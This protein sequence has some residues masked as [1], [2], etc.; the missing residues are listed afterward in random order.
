[1]NTFK[2]IAPIEPDEEFDPDAYEA[3][4]AAIEQM[5][6][7]TSNVELEE[8]FNP[9]QAR[10]PKGH[11]KAG[12]WRPKLVTG[13]GRVAP[14]HLERDMLNLMADI[15]VAQDAHGDH[16]PESQVR[17]IG[18]QVEKV[19]LR[20][21]AR[22]TYEKRLADIKAERKAIQDPMWD[23]WEKLSPTLTPEQWKEA[24]VR[25]LLTPAES[26]KLAD[27]ADE[28]I[29]TRRQRD[30][31]DRDA[32]LGVLQRIRPM[33]GRLKTGG[34]S[35]DDSGDNSIYVDY[36]T[37][38]Q[39]DSEVEDAINADLN[40]SLKQVL[41][42]IPKAWLDDTNSKGTVSWLF[43]MD[44][45]WASTTAD[46]AKRPDDSFRE[47]ENGVD[48]AL[49]G[50][51]LVGQVD[52][53]AHDVMEIEGDPY[54]HK[55]PKQETIDAWR[56]RR[57]ERLQTLA[58]QRYTWVGRVRT[59]NYPDKGLWA[60]VRGADDKRDYYVDWGGDLHLVS[61]P[62][63]QSGVQDVIPGRRDDRRVK[64]PIPITGQ[65]QQQIDL[66]ISRGGAYA[67]MYD[68]RYPVLRREGTVEGGIGPYAEIYDWVDD[69][70]V[71]KNLRDP[72]VGPKNFDPAKWDRSAP[73]PPVLAASQNTQIKIDPRE[74][75]ILLHELSHRMEIVYGSENQA[76]Y[77]PIPSATHAWRARRTRG[78]N[79]QKLDYLYPNS[80]YRGDEITYP[81]EF[82]DAYIGKLYPGQATEVLSMGMDMLWF[83]RYSERD[84]N[85]DPDMRQLILGLQATL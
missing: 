40:A 73:L 82:V 81:D 60:V 49:K 31:A 57:A 20:Y 26:K 11:P 8:A 13:A 71:M 76:G 10:F 69:N 80:D 44:R 5:T 2:P 78:E 34:F 6:G 27:L 83:P 17:A 25:D 53:A 63:K 4:I 79:T 21:S 56:E 32:M 35:V 45:A 33:G 47:M 23:K 85:Q 50:R 48:Q 14:G 43:S 75:A 19:A 58:K 30:F 37:G 54:P 74:K 15:T 42:V 70:G 66:A 61:N 64:G 24:E 84:I 36:L 18:E 12:Q 55:A 68:G 59:N 28:E 3:M 39:T 7:E 29:R 52:Q 22:K 46:Q 9:N 72:R 16:Q 51:L 62:A 67:G 41:K 77:N 38:D 65:Q 1:M